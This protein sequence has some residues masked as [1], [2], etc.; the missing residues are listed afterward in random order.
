MASHAYKECQG[1]S[2]ELLMPNYPTDVGLNVSYMEK[3]EHSFFTEVTVL[4]QCKLQKWIFFIP[5]MFLYYYAA[6]YCICAK[7]SVQGKRNLSKEQL[8]PCDSKFQSW[9]KSILQTQL[10]E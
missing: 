7:W 5:G 1:G 6:M 3:C 10:Y 9:N 4:M 2:T 8:F